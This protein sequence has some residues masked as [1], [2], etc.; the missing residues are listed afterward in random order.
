L[1]KV[2]GVDAEAAQDVLAQGAYP[3][4]I[5][6]GDIGQGDVQRREGHGSAADFYWN[7]FPAGDFLHGRAADARVTGLATVKTGQHLRVARGEQGGKRGVRGSGVQ[8]Q[9]RVNSAQPGGD[10]EVVADGPEFADIFD[11]RARC[12]RGGPRGGRVSLKLGRV[13]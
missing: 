7:G 8:M 5:T 1:L 4:S 10:I 12:R 11:G 6:A 3:F 2:Q 13:A 9:R